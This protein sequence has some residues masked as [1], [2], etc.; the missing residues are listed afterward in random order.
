MPHLKLSERQ[1]K[2]RP[3]QI[4]VTALER[5]DAGEGSL[6]TVLRLDQEDIENLRDR[7]LAFLEAGKPDK[8][9]SIYELLE[10][11]GDRSA[12]LC[13][14]LA[15]CFDQLG[16]RREALDHFQRGIV[17]ADEEGELALKES[18]LAWG[19]H[20]QNAGAR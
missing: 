12:G 4:D 14:I 7:G 3:A 17:L 6:A 10:S 8:C 16:E 13:F 1:N 2:K 11:K 15:S 18:A 20:L 9:K 5:F 19:A